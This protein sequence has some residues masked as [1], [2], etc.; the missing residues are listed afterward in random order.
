[1]T[2]EHATA[3]IFEDAH[4]TADMRSSLT[5]TLQEAKEPLLMLRGDVQNE[6]L[7]PLVS[8]SSEINMLAELLEEHIRRTEIVLR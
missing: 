5:M 8:I 6:L 1:M 2:A 7:L 3:D 4:C